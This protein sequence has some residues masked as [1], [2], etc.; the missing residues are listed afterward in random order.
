[1]KIF[2]VLIITTVASIPV[3]SQQIID[4]AI[5]K[6]DSQLITLS[7]YNVST[8]NEV[9]LS[10]GVLFDRT[11]KK[12]PSNRVLRI[13]GNDDK[14]YKSRKNELTEKIGEDTVENIISIKPDDTYNIELEPHDYYL[15]DGPI[16]QITYYLDNRLHYVI[17]NEK[18]IWEKTILISLKS[19]VL[20]Y[21]C[22]ETKND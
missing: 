5:N 3:K 17:E 15:I 20:N 11:Y 22:K 21:D 9:C 8:T 10:K 16:C 19:N 12:Q 14:A 1:M 2:L 6:V 7:L 18:I 4:A 13:L